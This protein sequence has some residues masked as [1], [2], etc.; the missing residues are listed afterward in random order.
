MNVGYDIE[1]CEPETDRLRFIEVKG[2]H[3]EADTI[4]VTKNEWL[5]ALNKREAF[6]L[7]LVMM[8]DGQVVEPPHYMWDPMDQLVH[9]DLTFGVTG[10]DLNVNGLLKLERREVAH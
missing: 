8:R 4:H 6:A 9:G 3:V 2:R 7:A 5:V 10:I 1:S